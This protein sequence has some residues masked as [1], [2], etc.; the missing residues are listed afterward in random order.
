MRRLFWFTLGFGGISLMCVF[1]LWGRTLWIPAAICVCGW[2]LLALIAAGWEKAGPAAMLFL[3]CGTALLWFSFFR[4]SYLAPVLPLDGQQVPLTVVVSE[5]TG[6]TQYGNR[7]SGWFQWEGKPY[8]ISLTLK[9]G[10]SVALGDRITGDFLVRL[11]VPEGER[12]S[13]YQSG[14]GRFLLGTQKSDAVIDSSHRDAWF[15][16][17]EKAANRLRDILKRCLPRETAP[18]AEALLLGDTDG[19]DY[20][21]DTA[22][23]LSGIR[24]VAAVSGLHVGILYGIIRTLTLRKRWLTALAGIPV[25][26]F[27]AAMAGFT[28]S[29]SRACLMT[30]LAMLAD[31]FF[32][33]Y[34][35]LSALS[36]GV[37]VLLLLN[38]FSAASVS[39]QLSTASVAGILTIY[40]GLYRWYQK[41]TAKLP[42]K[43]ILGK[44]VRWF[45]STVGITLSA[46][47]LTTPLS[48]CYFG[49]VSLIS[50]VTNL[51]T[52]WCIMFIFCGTAIL[53]FGGLIWLPV[54]LFLGK[55][56]DWPIRY[57]LYVAKTLARFPF[58]AVYTRSVWIVVW[59]ILC[60]LLIIA[61]SLRKKK[62]VLYT[63]IG[64]L[65]LAA[66][67][68]LSWWTPRRDAF[69]ATVLDVGQGQCILL[70][71]HGSSYLVDCGGSTGSGAA[72]AAAEEL[73]SQGIHELD[74]I[75]L[76]HLDQDH[77]NGLEY[78]LT[79]V[80]ARTLLVSPD[81]GEDTLFPIPMQDT[82]VSYVDATRTIPLG[83]GKLTLYPPS[84]ESKGNDYCICVLFETENYGILITGDRTAA[85]EWDLIQE[86]GLSDADILIAGHH[87][88]KYSTSQFLLDMVR[89]E[90]VVISVGKN[91]FYGH[92]APEL[93]ERLALYQCRI[94]RTDLDGTVI[95]RR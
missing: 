94:K 83:T 45:G 49:T 80:E 50:V 54:G 87:G 10:T 32:K 31:A 21:T 73:L 19:L 24:H 37:L 77:I 29:V 15:L 34:D 26:T 18:F 44:L 16:I 86:M 65:G 51:L 7:M 12:E 33:E 17:P 63:G 55:L 42:R 84:E 59:L 78:L 95:F 91:N 82:A 52:L 79:R 76:T 4:S 2:S 13:L 41:K 22:L 70:Q 3:G 72:D 30:A 64:A 90:T 60:Y 92:P 25:L 39:L 27:F 43:G 56:L 20:E 47:A 40:P 5:Q 61:F 48:A 69:R 58:A 35:S 36:F 38:P 74:G 57:V 85:G 75:I 23:K 1:F 68:F 88:S 81:N 93:L 62:P 66:A 46:M 89:P 6:N 8:K 14:S 53:C 9:T 71:S 11:T 67:L 28:P